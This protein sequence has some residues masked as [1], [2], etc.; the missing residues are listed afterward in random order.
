MGCFMNTA[1]HLNRHGRRINSP[2]PVVYPVRPQTE[3]EL[4]SV[5]RSLWYRYTT[6]FGPSREVLHH[7]AQ[8]LALV[9]GKSVGYVEH[10]IN[11]YLTH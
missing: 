1:I 5:G 8:Q 2:R 3:K 6:S 4:F 7:H 10:A 9:V 11:H